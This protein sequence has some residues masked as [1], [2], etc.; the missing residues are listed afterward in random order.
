MQASLMTTILS[1][2]PIS[3][4]VYILY[5][6]SYSFQIICPRYK[7]DTNSINRIL[8]CASYPIKFKP[9]FHRKEFSRIPSHIIRDKHSTHV[10]KCTFFCN[11]SIVIIQKS[12]QLYVKSL[13]LLKLF[14]SVFT[15][16]IQ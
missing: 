13:F 5:K 7:R 4:L 3:K 15:T 6:S 9:A 8:Y 12:I 10:K 2:L 1:C 16:I 11:K 14:R